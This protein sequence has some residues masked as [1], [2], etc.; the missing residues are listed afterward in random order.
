MSYNKLYALIATTLF[1]W[2]SGKQGEAAGD[3]FSFFP[4]TQALG[5]PVWKLDELSTSDEA[6]T[7]PKPA[8]QVIQLE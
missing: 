7:A 6:T 2:S 1:G 3:K 8:R 4:L 5:F